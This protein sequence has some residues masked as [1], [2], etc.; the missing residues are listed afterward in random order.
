MSRVS[1]WLF[2]S[3]M[4]S[5][6]EADSGRLP[7]A[8]PTSRPS[9]PTI[10]VSGV[11]S[12][13]LTVETNSSWCSRSMRRPLGDVAD[14][15]QAGRR[16]APFARRDPHLAGALPVARRYLDLL[17]LRGRDGKRHGAADQSFRCIVEQRDRGLVGELD[18]P[19]GVDHDDG[20]GRDG[21]Q[22]LDLAMLLDGT[23]RIF[24]LLALRLFPLHGAHR[25]LAPFDLALQRLVGLSQ[26]LRRRQCQDL[27]QER[28]Q[29]DCGQNGNQRGKSLHAAFGHVVRKPER[30]NSEQVRGAACRDEH[31]EGP[32]H[33]AEIDVR[34]LGDDDA[35]HDRDGEIGE[36]DQAVGNHVQPD[37]AGLPK[38]AHAVGRQLR[39]IEEVERIV[40]K[41]RHR[42]LHAW[43]GSLS[44][45]LP[46]T[47]GLEQ[48][49]C[50]NDGA[51]LKIS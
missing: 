6:R 5:R 2:L 8:L 34:A 20:V 38:Q 44:S 29:A 13:W 32:E 26:L 7:A 28:P 35:E 30:P 43:G 19:V 48:H 40:E 46:Q 51:L 3:A 31:R 25:R 27:G 15:H 4:V 22:P 1:R 37:Q 10:E 18:D 50:N 39:G 41:A 14:R 49:T 11:R 12:S 23:K 33:P 45:S 21:H 17:D 36:R 42:E 24:R 16:A 47:G 9:E